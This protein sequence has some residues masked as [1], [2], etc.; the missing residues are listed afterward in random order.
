MA[1]QN[2][3]QEHLELHYSAPSAL[4]YMARL[5]APQSEAQALELWIKGPVFYGSEVVLKADSAGAAVSFGLMLAGDHRA[6]IAGSWRATG[7]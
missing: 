6:A 2:R 4:V 7:D 5:S 1:G 3:A